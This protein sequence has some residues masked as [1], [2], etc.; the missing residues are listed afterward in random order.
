MKICILSQNVKLYSTRRLVEACEQHH[1]DVMVVDPTHCYMDITS[2]KP[3]IRYEGE[4]LPGFD[5]V[6]PRIGSN[7]TYYGSAI[8]RQFQM[9]GTFCVNG[10]IPITRS[11]DKLRS[12]Q[13]LSKSGLGMPRTGFAHSPDKIDDLI[14]NVGGAPVVIKLLEGTQGNGVVL[15]ET[16]KAAV[17]IVE[18]FM[19]MQANILVQEFIPEANG[20][21]IRCFVVGRKVVA[22]I[23]RQAVDG[24]FRSNLHKGGA[25]ES[26][27]LTPL[28]RKTAVE[29]AKAMDLNVCGVDLIRSNH[30]PLILEVNSSPGLEGIEKGSGKD[31]AG[32]IIEFIEKRYEDKRSANKRSGEG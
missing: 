10:S 2:N 5:A 25:I 6:I 3:S 20:A 27:K 19:S 29:A 12:L 30:G 7:I 23:K 32:C 1:H 16:H 4:E 26:V 28:E 11:R 24:E 15:G 18:A 31:V 8:V 21:D 9:M 22:A 14:R 13:V 17:S